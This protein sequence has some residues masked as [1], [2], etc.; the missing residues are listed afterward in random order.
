ME[1]SEL[2][3]RDALSLLSYLIQIRCKHAQF[4]MKNQ[5]QMSAEGSNASQF[6]L[7]DTGWDDQLV[8]LDHVLQLT[9]VAHV[10]NLPAKLKTTTRTERDTITDY[11]LT[12]QRM[13]SDSYTEQSCI[14]LFG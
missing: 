13:E 4:G 8:T 5:I 7:S 6:L 11:S 9:Q 10:V 14:K 3:F 2:G 12:G 1:G